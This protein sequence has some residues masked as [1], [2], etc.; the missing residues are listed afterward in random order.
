MTPKQRWI[1]GR[2]AGFAGLG[3]QQ[4]A[5]SLLHS[6]DD[7]LGVIHAALDAGIRLLDVAD[8]YAPNRHWVGQGERLVGEALRRWSGNRNEVVVATK[9]GHLL[10]DDPLAITPDGRPEHLVAACEASLR[11]LGVDR[12]DIYQLHSV[13]PATPLERSME[14]LARLREQ[15]KIAHIGLSNVN[16]GQLALAC[17]VAPVV[18]VQ[19]RY[20]VLAT[21]AAK[22]LEMC[23]ERDIAFLAY[24]PLGRSEAASIGATVE[25]VGRVAAR[26]GVSPQRIALA[27]LLAQ[28]DHVLPLPG[29]TSKNHPSDNV[30]AGQLQLTPAD[31]E[32]IQTWQKARS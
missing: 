17:G 15:G 6:I 12:I 14:A 19:S 2:P 29:A 4:L 31:L 18:S 26:H 8:V 21:Q 23:G 32:E 20:S 24:S 10:G 11:A 3:V 1:A 30:A 25:A 16:R 28:G 13:D 5:A 22:V 9:G 27:W 7:G